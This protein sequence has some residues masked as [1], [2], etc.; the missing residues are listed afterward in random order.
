M[1]CV[2]VLPHESYGHCVSI[3]KFGG[4]LQSLHEASDDAIHWLSLP[5]LHYSTYKMN[6][7]ATPSVM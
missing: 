4:G 6:E 1:H 3:T 7:M 2:L 5:R